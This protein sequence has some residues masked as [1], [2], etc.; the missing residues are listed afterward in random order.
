MQDQGVASLDLDYDPELVTLGELDREVRI[1]GGCVG[2]AWAM[3]SSRSR[4]W[5]LR[6]ASN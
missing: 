2:E 3:R 4:G 5:L 6:R 1:G